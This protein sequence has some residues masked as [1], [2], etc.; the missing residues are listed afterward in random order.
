LPNKNKK[1]LKTMDNR[2]CMGLDKFHQSLSTLFPP[3]EE[4]AEVDGN[5]DSDGVNR[6]TAITTRGDQHSEG[7]LNPSGTTDPKLTTRRVPVKFTKTAVEL[8]RETLTAFLRTVGRDLTEELDEG[9]FV[10]QQ[11]IR[12]EDIAR[13]LSAFDDD[14]DDSNPATT[15]TAATSNPSDE[16]S[17]KMKAFV[18]QA[19]ELLLQ[20]K[21]RE[22]QQNWEAER[23]APKRK[24]IEADRDIGSCGKDGDNTN[25]TE[26]GA[27][28]AI[29]TTKPSAKQQR[30]L[31]KK[32]KRKRIKQIKITAEM[33]AEQERLLNASKKALESSQQQQQQ[34]QQHRDGKDATMFRVELK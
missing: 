2:Q 14:D 16:T 3:S 29:A 4:H 20:R 25:R 1:N 15:T 10:S 8:L 26:S 30:Q 22:R 21:L 13:I 5:F 24:N 19:Q 11:P 17:L 32:R 18:S 28:A 23:S 7:P 34:Q 6:T 33:E 31:P 12:P 27:T 9:D